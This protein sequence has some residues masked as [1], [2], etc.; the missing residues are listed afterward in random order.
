MVHWSVVLVVVFFS[1]LAGFI[2][3]GFFAL[4][5]DQEKPYKK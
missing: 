2:T 3:C 4:L 5:H 1:F